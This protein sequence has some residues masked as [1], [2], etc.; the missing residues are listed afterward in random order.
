MATPSVPRKSRSPSAVR[1]ASAQLD[2][3]RR[4]D[5]RERHAGARHERLQEHVA[6]ARQRIRCLRSPD[7]GPPRRGRDRWRRCRRRRRRAA[8]PPEGDERGGGLLAVAL[9]QRRLQRAKLVAFMARS[10]PRDGPTQAGPTTRRRAPGPDDRIPAATTSPRSWNG[11]PFP[12]H[13]STTT[14]DTRICSGCAWEHSR[15]ASWTVD[16]K[17]SR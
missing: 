4:C 17:R 13:S 10:A 6:R 1:R 5:R 8:P 2:A 9:L 11:S 7:A 16:P 15:A 14:F 12:R 3:E